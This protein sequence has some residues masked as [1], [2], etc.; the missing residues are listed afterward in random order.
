M[1][2]FADNVIAEFKT[3]TAAKKYCRRVI[4]VAEVKVSKTSKF[5]MYW[6]VGKPVYQVVYLGDQ[7]G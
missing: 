3:I 7:D 2:P 1:R 5:D 4:G 6:P